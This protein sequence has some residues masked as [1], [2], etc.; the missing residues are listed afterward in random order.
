MHLRQ[1]ICVPGIVVSAG[2]SK[3]K[4]TEMKLR[5]KM[6]GTS[7]VVRCKPGIAGVQLPRTCEARKG[8]N[9][10]RCQLDPFEVMP[11]ECTYVD[12]QML[13]LQEAPED[14]PTGEMPQGIQMLC[15][16]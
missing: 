14:V 13:R 6:C 2:R 8:L 1:L 3:C 12:T 16:R 10:E 15:D 4:A 11:D 9:E 7:R 5:C